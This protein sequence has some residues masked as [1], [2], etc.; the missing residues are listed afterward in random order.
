MI[1]HLGTWMAGLCLATLVAEYSIADE[2]L[3]GLKWS[4]P[5][6]VASGTP[7]IAPSDA[8]VLFDGKDLSQWSHVEQWKV[9]DGA[10]VVGRG[11]ALSK[12]KFGDCQ[13]HI[14]FATPK[15]VEGNGQGRG[16][17]GVFLMNRYEVQILDSYKNKT[18]FDG[19]CGAIYKQTPPLVNASREPGEWQTYD[20]IWKAP[21]FLDGKLE[22]PAFITVLHNG[23]LILN[24]F[25]LQGDTS[26]NRAPKY[27]P[28]PEKDS[29][30]LQYHLHPLR[31]RNIW[32]REITALGHER[33]H[34]PQIVK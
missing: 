22:S 34:E 12:A 2:Y 4:E 29:I 28:H 14:E 26:Y 24:H 23:V 1:N 20:I 6:V 17:S 3:S 15:E 11:A 16:N 25:Q 27:M 7:S 19:Q 13:L 30:R 21:R 33:T 5:A 8:V 10:M 32:V 31:F 9:V 18:Y